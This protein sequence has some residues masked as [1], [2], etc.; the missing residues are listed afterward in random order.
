MKRIIFLLFFCF[1]ASTC[2]ADWYIVNQDGQVIA[3]CQ[4]EPDAEDLETRKEKAVFSKEDFNLGEVDYR[5]NKLSKHVKT[6]KELASEQAQVEKNAEEK[7]IQDEIRTQA[8]KAL[9]DKG[10]ELKHIDK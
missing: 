2:Y 3:K 4:Y 1:I 8:I 6:A 5:N 10:V 9:K 7:L